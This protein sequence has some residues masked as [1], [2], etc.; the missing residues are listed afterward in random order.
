VTETIVDIADR[1]NTVNLP[2]FGACT[3]RD[4]E[5]ITFPWGLPGFGTLR[6]FIALNLDGQ[7][8][9]VWLQSLDDP[10]V[11]IPVADP[12]QIFAD[13][14]PHLP[15]YALSSLDLGNPEDFVTLCVVVVSPGAVEMTMNLLAPVVVNLRTRTAR[16]ITLETGG[17]SVRTPIPRKRVAA[18]AGA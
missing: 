13:Y 6:R 4:D 14:A 5:V 1:T 18:A 10:S 11:A 2:R 15:P 8:R 3:Y 7:E 9:F 12:W 16:Q 17:Y